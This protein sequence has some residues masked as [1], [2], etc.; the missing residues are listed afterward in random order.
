[1]KVKILCLLLAL[2]MLIPLTVACGT[3]SAET[4]IDADYRV[5]YPAQGDELTMAAA[6]YLKNAVSKAA[7]LRLG[8]IKDNVAPPE[9]TEVKQIFVGDAAS[10]PDLALEDGQAYAFTVTETGIFLYA[11]TPAHLYLAAL[12][13]TE[14]WLSKNSGITEEGTVVISPKICK[15]LN[16]L[17]L[18]GDRVIS[19]MS[20]NLRCA[21]DG[22]GN[23]IADRAPRLQKL[24]EECAPDLLGTQ[25]TTAH[26]NKL[27]KN[28]FGDVYGMVGCSREGENATTG[29]WN[30]ILYKK[31]RFN[32]KESG[33][34]WLTDTPE[35]V[36]RVEGA[37][38]NRICTWVL[39]EDKISGKTIFF[40]N[41]HLDHSN[42][43]VRNAQAGYLLEN[44]LPYMTQYPSYVTGDFNA[45]V[46]SAPYKTV[47]KE[48]ANARKE[49]AA[50][51]SEVD[52]TFH[53]YGKEQKQNEIDFCFYHPDLSIA[54]E[55][56]ILSKNYG[57]YV[58]DHYGL[59][60]TFLPR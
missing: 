37:L 40:A 53:G 58:S 42:D 54:L 3:A 45:K 49:A 21:D 27:L 55:Y 57:G 5:V 59:M 34:F 17:D 50:D 19:V 9:G 60:C 23:D 16:G 8:F 2:C 13:V 14:K 28:A 32:L 20:Q 7:D 47:M 26:W 4:V 36:S 10:V 1:M 46:G 41:T 15:E 48:L 44:L 52:Y 11:D 6:L 22:N 56:R 29:E 33:N 12:K 39:L 35:K 38:C 18:E 30:T 43:E 51:R 24:I 25:E 31:S